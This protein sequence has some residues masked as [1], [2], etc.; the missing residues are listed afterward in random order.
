MFWS[1]RAYVSTRAEVHTGLREQWRRRH[2]NRR[3]PWW[4]HI[5]WPVSQ[6]TDLVIAYTLSAAAVLGGVVVLL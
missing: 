5:M 4:A 3:I 2:G 1:A 6:R